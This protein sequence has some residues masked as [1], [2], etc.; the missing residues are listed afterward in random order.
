MVELTVDLLEKV[1][2]LAGEKLSCRITFRNTSETESETVAWASAQIH[3]QCLY[4]EE[5]VKTPL[6]TLQSPANDTAFVPNKGIAMP[7]LRSMIMEN[8]STKFTGRRLTNSIYLLLI[9]DDS[10]SRSV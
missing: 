4:R 1:T 2:F 6:D 10:A 3:C 8:P 5:L 7:V 9:L